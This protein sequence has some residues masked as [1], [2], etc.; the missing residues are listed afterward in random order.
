MSTFLTP[1]LK[2]YF[3]KMY[4]QKTAYTIY[5]KYYKNI[6]MRKYVYLSELSSVAGIYALTVV[7]PSTIID[8]FGTRIIRL[9]IYASPIEPKIL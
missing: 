8:R 7:P 5:G 2:E 1:N 3:Q 4:T 9:I 6:I